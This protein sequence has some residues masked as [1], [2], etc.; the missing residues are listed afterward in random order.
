MNQSPRPSLHLG[1]TTA[2]ILI[3]AAVAAFLA[4][5]NVVPLLPPARGQPLQQGPE[6]TSTVWG[7]LG[8]LKLIGG[9]VSG[10]TPE[11]RA[12]LGF[13]G[14]IAIVK[15]S[16]V[17]DAIQRYLDDASV[18][19]FFVGPS[20][21]EPFAF[22]VNDGQRTFSSY[23][24]PGKGSEQETQRQSSQQ[25]ERDGIRDEHNRARSAN[26]V[27][28]I[29]PLSTR[30]E[31]AKYTF[32]NKV[33]G[34]GSI[35]Q[36]PPLADIG[37][38]NKQILPLP[39]GKTAQKGQVRT[40]SWLQAI[41]QVNPRLRGL[42]GY[43]YGF[44]AKPQRPGGCEPFLGNRVKQFMPYVKFVVFNPSHDMA[45][46][47]IRLNLTLKRA[48]QSPYTISNVDSPSPSSVRTLTINADSTIKPDASLVFP[49]EFGF[50]FI[51]DGY[52]PDPRIWSNPISIFSVNG[53]SVEEVTLP[54]SFIASMQKDQRQLP[55]SHRLLV[56]ATVEDVNVVSSRQPLK[57]ERVATLNMSQTIGLGSCPF[58]IY[59]DRGNKYWIEYGTVLV[60]RKE[61][62]LQGEEKHLIRRNVSKIR[63]EEREDEI[64]YIDSI[65]V[66]YKD[67]ENQEIIIKAQDPQ[68]QNADGN[69]AILR[70]G[71]RLEVDFTT[72]PTAA[73]DV[74]VRING[75]YIPES[76]GR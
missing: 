73:S 8:V 43:K 2:R 46:Q 11:M 68:I 55:F 18:R 32:F 35:E 54:S 12:K 34:G 38:Y 13:N 63:I 56:G 29:K 41:I 51:P 33:D 50:Q 6:Q 39:N 1:K 64:S 17:Y 44:E 9:D 31:D 76:A 36:Y 16:P 59:F 22:S 19:S 24:R 57:G 30:I 21:E 60:D 15:Q 72:V 52:T 4:L 71:E 25:F 70:K 7:T 49:V 26:L 23:V 74:T 66:G 47:P 40:N 65:A 61:K 53:K 62:E 3:V 58:L 20:E 37:P 45:S 67:A 28:A 42:I 75:Y 69:Y 27:E 14:H 5:A 48:D 10:L